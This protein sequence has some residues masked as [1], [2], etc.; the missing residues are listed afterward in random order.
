VLKTCNQIFDRSIGHWD[1]AALYRKP[2]TY[3]QFCQFD[4]PGPAL[5]DS[6][7]T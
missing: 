3:W 1:R 2:L 5:Y 6:T 7:H 4:E